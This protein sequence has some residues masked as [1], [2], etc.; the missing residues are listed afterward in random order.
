MQATIVNP[1]HEAIREAIGSHHQE[2]VR[3]RQD[4][5]DLATVFIHTP[6][7]QI[8]VIFMDRWIAALSPWLPFGASV[9]VDDFDHKAKLAVPVRCQAVFQEAER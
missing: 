1:T 4:H 8:P 2:I 3:I 9:I 7:N 5:G 6:L